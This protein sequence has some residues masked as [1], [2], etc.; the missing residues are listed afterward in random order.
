MTKRGKYLRASEV[1]EYVYCARAWR[2][3]VDGRE[4]ASGHA[5]RAAGEAW[6]LA[7]GAAVVRARRMRLLAG[8]AFAL[9]LIVG[10]LIL[11]LGWR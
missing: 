7:H 3:R 6:H 4:P 2:L 5:Q 10:L 1:A 9:A 8:F 11:L